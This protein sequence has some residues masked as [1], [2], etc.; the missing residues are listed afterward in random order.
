MSPLHHSNLYFNSVLDNIWLLPILSLCQSTIMPV[1]NCHRLTQTY[2][3]MPGLSCSPG[4]SFH[5]CLDFDTLP[6]FAQWPLTILQLFGSRL[7]RG[8]CF[9]RWFQGVWFENQFTIPFY[10]RVVLAKSK[11]KQIQFRKCLSF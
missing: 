10:E 4:Q 2:R 11:F 9:G 6:V 3:T 1:D 7:N 8:N 5:C